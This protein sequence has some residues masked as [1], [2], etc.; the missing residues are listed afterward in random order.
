M[1]NSALSGLWLWFGYLDRAHEIC[2]DIPSSE[3]S[4][5]HGIMHRI[6]GDF[7]NAKYW[8]RRVGSHPVHAE[9]RTALGKISEVATFDAGV[10]KGSFQGNLLLPESFVDQ[11]ELAIGGTPEEAHTCRWIQTCEWRSLMLYCLSGL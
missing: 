1:A 4:Y 11:C 7:W 3:G 9:V 10:V 5:W 8:M 2:Q 6:E